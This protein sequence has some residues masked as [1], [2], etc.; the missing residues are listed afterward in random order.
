MITE[1]NYL[2]VINLLLGISL[3]AVLHR[4]DF[5][6]SGMFR[7]AFLFRKFFMLRSLFLLI[8]ISAIIFYGANFLGLLNSYPL[9]FFKS[10][11]IAIIIGGIIF[12]IGM[13]LAGG[14]VVGTL[15]KMGA[16][17]SSSG[18]AF[19]GMILGGAFYAEIHPGWSA[20]SNGLVVFEGSKTLP[21]LFGIGHGFL[22][23]IL[24]LLSIL[25]IF[26]W[27]KEKKMTQMAFAEGYLPPWKAAF[28]I[29]GLGLLSYYFV[30]W[31]MGITTSYAKLGAYIE[32]I[33]FP[34]HVASLAFFE[35]MAGPR[36]DMIAITQGPLVFGI[37]FG[38]FLSALLLKEFR[39]HRFPP[40]KQVV[41]VFFGGFVM[42]LG[43]RMASGCNVWYLFGYIPM[44]GLQGFFFLGGIIVGAYVGTKILSG[45]IITSK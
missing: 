20:F 26:K 19:V 24:I 18:L 5:C 35:G 16:G 6:M 3:G 2:I 30:G 14:C 13:V 22:L 39:I 11:S 36:I 10:P 34:A 45:Y 21:E 29:A 33:F 9:S 41:S 15:Y 40:K 25:I 38:S 43:A 27:T 44:L 1:N 31:P 8:V 23:F 7:D 42:S 4:S 12:G 17:R 37:V 28:A 32:N